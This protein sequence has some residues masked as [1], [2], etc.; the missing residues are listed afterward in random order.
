MLHKIHFI[1]VAIIIQLFYSIPEQSSFQYKQSQL[2]YFP[3]LP[4]SVSSPDGMDIEYVS[5]HTY[6][7]YEYTLLSSFLSQ[8]WIYAHQGNHIMLGFRFFLSLH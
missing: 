6:V 5:I 1:S 7:M 4:S 8:P 3:D 2:C